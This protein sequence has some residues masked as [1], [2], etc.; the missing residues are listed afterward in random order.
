MLMKRVAVFYALTVFC[1][2]PAAAQS[3]IAGLVKD[4]SGAVLPGVSVEAASPSLIEGV[5]SAVTDGTGQ[6]R[7]QDLRPGE[8]TVT[9]SL[10]GFRQ[11]KRTGI[12]LPVSFTA[13]VNADMAV[14]TLEEAITV[15]AAS[16]LIDVR[17]SVSQSVVNREAL[18][19][20]PTGKDPFAVGQLIAG[21]TTS[22]PDVGGTQIMQQP[23]LQVHGS[24]NNDNVFMVDGVQIQHIGFGGNQ[25]GFYFNDGLM[26]EISYQTS[27]LPAEAPVGGVQINMI[28]RD[29]GNLFHGSVFSTAANSSLQSDNLDSDLV[30]LGFKVQNR[31]QNV[32]DINGTFGGPLRKDRLWFFGTYRRWSADNYLGNTFTSTGAQAVDDQHI[33]DATIRLTTQLAKKHKLSVHYDRSIKFRGHRPN[34]YISVSTNDPLSDVVQTTQKNYIGEIKWTSPISTRLLAE[35]AVFT[36]PVNYSLSFEPDAAP[37]AVATLDQTRSAIYGVSPRQ[38]VNFA[39]MFTYAANLSYV[40][41]AHAIKGGMQV[42][43]GHSEENF[44]SRGDIVQVIVNDAAN[45]VRLLNTPS[46]HKE[47]G[48]NTAF[49][50][51]D[52]WRF[53]RL[54]LNP[55]LRYEHFGMS[56]PEQG[57]ASGTWVGART[58]PAQDGIIN[59]NTVSPR[60]GFS[61][62]V[63][64]DGQTAL[65]GGVSRYDRLEG[66]TIIQP[67]NQRNIAFQTC[68]W[69]D[70]NND[71]RAQ[72]SEIAF[73]RCTGSLVPSLGQVDS[74]LKR[75][76]Q[77][78]Y[79]AMVQRQIG[80]RTSV[81]VGYYGRRFTDLYTTVNALVPP[82]AYSPVPI[83]NPLTG[84]PMTVYNQ[85][86]ATRGAVQNRLVTV[87]DLKQTYNG[88]EFQVNTRTA[89]A[90]VFGGFTIGRD[91]GDQDSGDLNNPNNRINNEGNIGFDSPYQIRGGFNYRLPAAFQLS[92]S[93]REASGLP[94][95]RVYTVT[96]SVVPGLTQVT[97][98]VQVAERGEF[99]YPWVNLVD[100]RV[101]RTFTIGKTRIEPTLD[102]FNVFNNNAV[103]SAVTTVGPSLGRP[104]AIVMGRLLRLGGRMTF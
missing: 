41:G 99:R 18:D 81:S 40:T 55:G 77:W 6:F 83:T 22:T 86:P 84:Q 100:L 4:S 8:Y 52:S 68:P 72:N 16:P 51:Q 35:A 70:T 82:T 92:G 56:I 49:Y 23:T 60:L 12:I 31:V 57:A 73:A 1:A 89:K 80:S 11:V 26:D 32:Y 30:A 28:P 76:H 44:T 91:F 104:S 29:G 87:P 48:I 10:T 27:S 5:R 94:Q 37:D 64:G 47:E 14:G 90:T 71:L 13:T 38:D 34:N 103:T 33:T 61:M 85:D 74:N 101:A 46:G 7:I 93:I 45:S 96:T 3:A 79:T 36:L 58:F 98:N 50:I 88:V 25:T 17:S 75:P 53:S 19:T 78:E 65:K 20:I 43:T 9:F 69:A 21:V 62:D 97:Q 39:R 67:L 66:I 24:S 63:F 59:W 2:A 15:S 42:R 54:T 102:L 95:T